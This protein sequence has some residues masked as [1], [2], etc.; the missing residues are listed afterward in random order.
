M[1]LGFLPVVILVVAA[2]FATNWIAHR[3]LRPPYMHRTEG[4]NWYDYSYE[5][6]G[7]VVESYWRH[8][9]GLD[10]GEPR[11]AVYAWHG[12]L[13]HHGIFSL[14]PIWL[15]SVGGLALWLRRQDKWPMRE[16]AAIIAVASLACLVFYL[17]VEQNGRNYG[18]ST[19]GFRWVFWL[20]PLWLIAMLPALDVLSRR[21]WT[22]ALALVLLALSALSASYPTWNPWSH[23]WLYNAMR[24]L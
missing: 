9:G 21:R 7:R 18:G 15:L 16:L 10:R 12:L 11:T 23:P 5:R 4:D 3:S 24:H 19:C 2:F 1:L 6:N 8:P 17:F 22:R 13:G 14:T 20:A